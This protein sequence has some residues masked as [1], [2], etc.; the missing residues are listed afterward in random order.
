VTS[1]QVRVGVPAD[2]DGVMK[3]ALMGASENGLVHPNQRKILEH[4]WAALNRDHGIMGVIGPV[5]GELE[6]AVLLRICNQW[7]TDRD[8]IEELGL[9]VH[10]DH[11]AMKGQGARIGTGGRAAELCKFSKRVA[12][13][14]DM[15]LMIGVLS[16]HRTAGKMRLYG[17]IFGEMAG[18]Y[19]LY[20][21]K[22][23][24]QPLLAAAE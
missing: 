23:G 3:L 6:G 4:V 18:A 1:V 14:L 21:A 7:Y 16:N 20:N 8:V 17:R 2:V 10:P 22:T 11:R 13:Q 24:D 5:G 12:E 9:F 19:F 15:P